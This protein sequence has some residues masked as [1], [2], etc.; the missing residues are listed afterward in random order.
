VRFGQKL[1]KKYTCIGVNGSSC[2]IK[3][4]RRDSRCPSC[5]KIDKANYMA[6][7]SPTYYLDNKKKIAA[8]Y[9]ER[10]EEISERNKENREDRA[11]YEASRR[12]AHPEV[13][14][15]KNSRRRHRGIVKMDA[16]DRELSRAYRQAIKHDLCFY[17]GNPGEE[18]DHYIP[19][20]K[21]G[22]D[23]WWNIVRACVFCN[24]SKKDLMPEDFISRNGLPTMVR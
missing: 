16:F 2:A 17:C 21:G 22:T 10:K 23:H 18:D 19:L 20:A 7:Y 1:E 14:R 9:Q 8:R 12:Q 3:V 11:A 15:A 24:R 6:A 13:H 5:K 4:T